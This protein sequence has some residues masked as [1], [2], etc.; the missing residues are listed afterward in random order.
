M[1]LEAIWILELGRCRSLVDFSVSGVVAEITGHSA[2]D[3]EQDAAAIRQ[4]LEAFS[5]TSIEA[6][7][8]QRSNS[9]RFAAAAWPTLVKMLDALKLEDYEAALRP[10][11]SPSAVR[12]AEERL[13]VELPAD[14]KEFLLITNGLEMLSIDAPALKPVEEL[15]WETPEELGLDWMRVSLGCEVDASE[16]E[17]LPA[18]NRVLVLSDG[19]EESMWYVEPDVVGQAAQVLKTMGRS[20]ELVGPS[21]WWCAGCGSSMIYYQSLICMISGLCSTSLGSL[22]SDGTR[23]SGDTSSTSPRNLRRQVVR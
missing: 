9:A 22:K 13:G 14:Y 11:A 4:A 18:M 23:A 5:E 16:E 3:A 19:G 10:P 15:C 7:E 21:G 6:E 17:Q 20:D 2:S 12:A 1:S 8:R